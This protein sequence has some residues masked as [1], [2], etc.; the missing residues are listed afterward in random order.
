MK[1]TLVSGRAGEG[2]TTFSNFCVEE[3]AKGPYFKFA[4]VASFAKGVKDVATLM[5]WDGNKDSR[6]RKFL[7]SIGNA[8]R[9]YRE[10]V[11]AEKCLNWLRNLELI[12]VQYVFIDDWRFPN[13][14]KFIDKYYPVTKCRVVRGQKY[15]TLWGTSN[16]NDLSEVSLPEPSQ[17]LPKH[18]FYDIMIVNEEGLENLKRATKEFLNKFMEVK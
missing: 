12:G 6:G 1:V 8:G 4:N 16:Y 5:G 10:S 7:Q 15:H 18:P 3:L 9:E 13:E 2:K 14:G 17:I 11:W